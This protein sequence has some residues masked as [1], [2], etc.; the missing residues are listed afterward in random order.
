MVRLTET[1]MGDC[2]C[3]TGLATVVVED[4]LRRDRGDPNT[5]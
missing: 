2:G 3:D 4:F 5:F 1:A